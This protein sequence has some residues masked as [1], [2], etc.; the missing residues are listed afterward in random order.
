MLQWVGRF[1]CRPDIEDLLDRQ[2]QEYADRRERLKANPTMLHPVS[3]I[4]ESEVIQD[5]AWPDGKPFYDCPSDEFRLNFVFSGDGFNPNSNREA[6]QTTSSTAIYLF[7][8][9]LP[10]EERYKPQNVYLVGV[11]PGPDKPS[12]TQ[13]NH[14]TSLIVDELLVFWETGVR[15]TRTSKRKKGVLVR[16]AA[17]QVLCDALGARQFCGHGSPTS[18]FFC[19]FCWLRYSNIENFD[20]ASWPARDA[21]QHRYWAELWKVSD[22]TTRQKIFDDHGIR[23]S[24]LLRLPYFDPVKHVVVDAMHNLYLGL[25]QRHCRSIWGMDYSLEDGDGV[26]QPKGALPAMPSPAR[27]ADGRRA[28]E[29]N[30]IPRLTK[31]RTDVLFHLCAELD[32]RRG[33]KKKDFLRELIQWVSLSEVIT[34]PIAYHLFH[35]LS[36]SV[37]NRLRSCPIPLKITLILTW[38]PIRTITFLVRLL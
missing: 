26:S 8:S 9:N 32:L 18:T 1:I 13:I 7:C 34:S 12:T 30:D 2:K 37:N 31:I 38:C 15:Y 3:D 36:L 5:F 27:M 35:P 28:L 14:Y 23:Y 19:T 21:K 10:L 4:L 17:N 25:L 22:T 24:P 16:A 11:I 6:K 20:K 33:G 29:F